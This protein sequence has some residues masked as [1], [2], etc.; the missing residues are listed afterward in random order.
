[1]SEREQETLENQ[2]IDPPESQGG[3]GAAALSGTEIKPLD[4]PDG[5]GGT[6]GGKIV[7]ITNS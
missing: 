6:G 3:S 5:N 4:P 1:M 7:P 2:V